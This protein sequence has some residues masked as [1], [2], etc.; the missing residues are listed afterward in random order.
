MGIRVTTSAS[1][2][3]VTYSPTQPLY[4]HSSTRSR[5]LFS[6]LQ[7]LLSQSPDLLNLLFYLTKFFD[8]NSA[9]EET[10]KYFAARTRL[11]LSPVFDTTLLKQFSNQDEQ[12][13]RTFTSRRIY[14]EA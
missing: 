9:T 8:R 13:C 12:H 4:Q 6:S 11:F 7:F 5:S 1:S 2:R 10:A 3:A 14:R